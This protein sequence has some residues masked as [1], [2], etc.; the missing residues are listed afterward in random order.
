MTYDGGAAGLRGSVTLVRREAAV[1]DAV[2]RPP[3]TLSH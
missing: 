2:V 3:G 1:R